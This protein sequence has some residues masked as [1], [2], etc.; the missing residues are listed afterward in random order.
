MQATSAGSLRGASTPDAQEAPTQPSSPLRAHGSSCASGAASTA[1]PER[2]PAPGALWE[3]GRGGDGSG[4]GA[5]CALVEERR[6]RSLSGELGGGAPVGGSHGMPHPAP[7]L[8]GT[9]MR[10]RGPNPFATPARDK[11]VPD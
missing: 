1:A 5:E 7:Q 6:S 11:P 3:P 9:G 8:P 10:R 2:L 4:L